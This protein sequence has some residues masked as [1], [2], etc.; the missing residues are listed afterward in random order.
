[1]DKNIITVKTTDLATETRAIIYRELTNTFDSSLLRRRT[2]QEKAFNH[3][4]Y[5]A[6]LSGNTGFV[7]WWD[8][9]KSAFIEYL[10]VHKDY[11]M[12]GLGT[13]LI[14]TVKDQGKIVILETN[15]H[16][17][18]VAFHEKNGFMTNSFVYSPIQINDLPP[19][20]LVLMS[21]NRQLTAEEYQ[22]FIRLISSEELQF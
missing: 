18:V 5:R 20:D 13:K 22:E 7:L 19:S 1:M 10:W 21:Y 11:R 14:N 12:Q 17:S 8:F 2:S 3:K 6:T 4:F 16:D 9:P 15:P